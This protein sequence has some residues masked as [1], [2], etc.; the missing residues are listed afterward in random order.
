MAKP[1]AMQPTFRIALD[2]RPDEAIAA[3]R[4][5]V[6]R[7]VGGE[8]A[9]AAGSCLD[10]RVAPEERRVWSPHLSI[11]V[12]DSEHGTELVGRFSPRPE[13]WTLVMMLYFAAAFV[14]IGGAVY[15]CVQWL[16]GSS[17]LALLLVP[18]A[19]GAILGLHLTSLAGQQ[20]SADQMKHLRDCFDRVLA[21]AA[22]GRR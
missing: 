12:G 22:I 5:A 7:G 1:V 3:L 10:F 19:L 17:P 14:A 8:H 2:G 9:D 20:L 15:G 6:T 4:S 16:L 21:E 18:V 11:Q 13:I